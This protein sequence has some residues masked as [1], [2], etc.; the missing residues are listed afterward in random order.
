MEKK[1]FA[2]IYTVNFKEHNARIL[3]L[4]FPKISKSS[5]TMR[6]FTHKNFQ[7]TKTEKIRDFLRVRY[8]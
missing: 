7:G 6:K 5:E 3:S 2:L 1:F 8:D 4:E